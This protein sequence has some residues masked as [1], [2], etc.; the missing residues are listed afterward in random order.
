MARWENF[1]IWR[2]RL[3][4]WRADNVT[5]YV[6]FRHK[7][8]LDDW[9]RATLYARLMKAQMGKLDIAILCVLPEK[10]EMLL[11]VL[12]QPS[13]APYELTDIIEKCKRKAG[14]MIVKKSGE[15]WPPFY[16]ESFDRIIRDEEELESYWLA[17]LSSPVEEQ[18]VIEPEEWPTL[19]VAD[20]P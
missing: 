10:S 9:E 17:I 3:P 1:Q 19:H 7:R 18:F 5:Y 8:E 20:S 14:Q 2:G 15:R 11:R 12:E 16:T 4:H 13:G 6:T